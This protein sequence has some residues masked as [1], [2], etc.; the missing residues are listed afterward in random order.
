V[1][2][3][4]ARWLHLTLCDI[5]FLDDIDT[6]RLE[7][8]TDAV[9]AAM[10][11]QPRLRLTLGPVLAFQDAVTL[12]AGPEDDLRQLWGRVADAMRS[13]GL[14]P[15][16]H[17]L[18]TFRPHVTLGYVNQRIDLGTVW[19]ALGDP[20]ARESVTVD[21]LTLAAVGRREGHY[22]WDCGAVISF[23]DGTEVLSRTGSDS[24][25]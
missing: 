12:A 14:A 7:R 2:P 11:A 17:P 8:L 18:D 19:G 4:P 22:Q 16:H 25:P 20:S 3:V 15:E 5:G 6:D 13:V 10:R 1:D 24:T 9:S 23:G 21:R